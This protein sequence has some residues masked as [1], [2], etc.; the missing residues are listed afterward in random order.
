M[1]FHFSLDTIDLA[2][3]QFWKYVQPY[4][5]FTFRG[6]MGAGK[7]TFISHVCHCLQVSDAVTSPTYSIINEYRYP[8][9][10]GDQLLYHMDFY[11]LKDEEEVIHAG[12]EDCM[13]S[14][15]VCMVEWPDRAPGLFDASTVEVYITTDSELQR[16][17]EVRLP[18]VLRVSIK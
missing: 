8:G 11:R 1:Y 17:V 12:V 7:T 16:S 2:A 18:S 9:K 15:A 14:G 10:T 5:I 3:Q 6:S 13:N 4:K